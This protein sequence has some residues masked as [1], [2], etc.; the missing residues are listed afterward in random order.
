MFVVSDPADGGIGSADQVVG[1]YVLNDS[2]RTSHAYMSAKGLPRCSDTQIR[3]KKF[4]K[5]DCYQVY[6]HF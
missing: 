5:M 3:S 4:E 2:Q 6:A 1:V